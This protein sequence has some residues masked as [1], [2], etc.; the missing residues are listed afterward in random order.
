MPGAGDIHP[1]VPHV[2]NQ[3]HILA[4]HLLKH[5]KQPLVVQGEVLKLRVKL[6]PV[7][8]VF[9]HPLQFFPVALIPGVESAAGDEARVRLRLRKNIAIDMLHLMSRGGGRKHHGIVDMRTSQNLQQLID[10]AVVVGRLGQVKV[11]RRSDGGLGGD[12]FGKN[13]G[14]HINDFHG[15]SLLH[16]GFSMSITHT[17]A[18]IK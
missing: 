1:R 14:V 15:T 11:L 9:P 13:V 18:S 3:E 6:H 8:P 7:Y 4:L 17:K 12:L 16:G 10:A 5:G 2:G